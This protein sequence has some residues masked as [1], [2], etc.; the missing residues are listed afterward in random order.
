M[1][2]L[3]GLCKNENE[4]TML[5]L[6]D[7][8]QSLICCK[9]NFWKA[10]LLSQIEFRKQILTFIFGKSQNRSHIETSVFL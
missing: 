6:L 8:K 10:M 2:D 1:V 9:L 3:L 7:T 5:Q 4:L